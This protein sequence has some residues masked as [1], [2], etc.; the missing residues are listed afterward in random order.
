M[1]YATTSEFTIANRRFKAYNASDRRTTVW[2]Y[3]VDDTFVD[4]KQFQASLCAAIREAD[5]LG[6][7]SHSM[8][9]MNLGMID[10]RDALPKEAHVKDTQN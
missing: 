3:Y 7:I 9:L 5:P 6:L 4:V 1:S 10:L 2:S 8:S